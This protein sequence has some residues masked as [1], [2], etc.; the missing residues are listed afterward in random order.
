MDPSLTLRMTSLPPFPSTSSGQANRLRVTGFP[1]H[2]ANPVILS[3]LGFLC[4]LRVLGGAK[5][6]VWIDFTPFV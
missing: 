4:A 2:P 6:L 3:A 5:S 1:V